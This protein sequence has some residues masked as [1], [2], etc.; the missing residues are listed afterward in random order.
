MEG[1]RELRADDLVLRQLSGCFRR[2]YWRARRDEADA[3]ALW[4]G[5]WNWLAQWMSGEAPLVIGAVTRSRPVI[6]AARAIFSPSRIRQDL[7]YYGYLHTRSDYRRRGLGE[8]VMKAGL[9]AIKARGGKICC[10]YVAADNLASIRLNEKIGFRKLPFA[11]VHLHGSVNECRPLPCARFL[12]V[13]D[14][15]R[16]QGADKLIAQIAS[17]QDGMALMLES[18]TVRRPRRWWG[19]PDSRLAQLEYAGTIVGIARVGAGGTIIV[20]DP[21]GVDADPAAVLV[22]CLKV[23]PHAA[24]RELCAFLPADVASAVQFS[25]SVRSVLNVWWHDGLA[26]EGVGGDDP[27]ERS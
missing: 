16:V 2:S 20:A 21:R 17:G 12:D 10:G 13:V 9:A 5:A 1:C 6:V 23:L 26:N 4:P 7:W 27:V 14:I 22:G 3:T 11:R 18:L 8:A 15:R 19:E 25:P 24:D